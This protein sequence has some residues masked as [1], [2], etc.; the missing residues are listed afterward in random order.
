MDLHFTAEGF[1]S[2][3]FRQDGYAL[4]DLR[5][6]WDL[7]DERTQIAFFARNMLDTEYFDSAV[8]L[9]GSLGIG[10]VYFAAPRSFGGE[11][12]YRWKASGRL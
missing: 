2:R 4:I 8:D 9:S 1:A 7:A 12:R 11:I 3:R 6:R 5:I 10:G